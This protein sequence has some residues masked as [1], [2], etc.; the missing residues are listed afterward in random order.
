MYISI[1]YIF[2]NQKPAVTFFHHDAA[3]FVSLFQDLGRGK[4]QLSGWVV[5]SVISE[6]LVHVSLEGYSK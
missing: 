4:V 1:A 2:R 5:N 3:P 6:K